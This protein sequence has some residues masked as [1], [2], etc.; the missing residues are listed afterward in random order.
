MEEE[1]LSI[2]NEIKIAIYVLLT[3]VIVGVIANWIRA[4]ASMKNLIR[5]KLDDFF[6]EEACRLHEEGKSKELIGHCEDELK[7]R[8]NSSNALWFL[9]KAYYQIEDFE[10]S[11]EHF[12]KLSTLEP[13]WYE[14]DIKPFMEKIDELENQAH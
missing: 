5:N 13:S 1:I 7:K 6:K 10:Q 3:V 2:L 12:E 14:S 9:A 8:P 11:K 4:G